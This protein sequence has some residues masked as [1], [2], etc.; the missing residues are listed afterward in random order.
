M[1]LDGIPM[2]PKPSNRALRVS[3]LLTL[4]V[5]A[6]IFGSRFYQPLGYAA[7]PFC[8]PG[9]LILGADET[10]ERYGYWGEIIWFTLLSWPCFVLY[11]ALIDRWWQSHKGRPAGRVAGR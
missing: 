1:K 3:A 5:A 2:K 11:A 10:M 9:L 4:L 7:L 6:L 8:Q